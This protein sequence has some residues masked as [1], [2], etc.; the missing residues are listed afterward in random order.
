MLLNNREKVLLSEALDLLKTL[1]HEDIKDKEI[2]LKHEREIIQ[3]QNKLFYSG[4]NILVVPNCVNLV[5][6]DKQIDA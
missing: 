5:L 4:N 3:L 1:Y 6:T 2:R